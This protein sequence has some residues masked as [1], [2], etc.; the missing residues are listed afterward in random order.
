MGDVSQMNPLLLNEREPLINH[1]N[2]RQ[3]QIGDLLKERESY[4]WKGTCREVCVKTAA[5]VLT[6]LNCILYF[7]F[8]CDTGFC[9]IESGYTVN[10]A[11][12]NR[13]IQK[14]TACFHERCYWETVHFPENK[15]DIAYR[16]LDPFVLCCCCSYDKKE[17]F[18]TAPERQVMKEKETQ[19]ERLGQAL[20]DG[21]CTQEDSLVSEKPVLGFRASQRLNNN[22]HSM[23]QN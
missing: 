10:E 22:P 19:L 5:C 18:L 4:L 16:A 3:T 2:N 20:R 21:E 23:F 13:T 9:R 1:S 7:I 11:N 17:H 14:V 15:C 6:P 12:E 8:S